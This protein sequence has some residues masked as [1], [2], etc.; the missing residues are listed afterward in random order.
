MQKLTWYQKLGYNSAKHYWRTTT[1]FGGWG[2]HPN[3]TRAEVARIG[4]IKVWARDERD[5]IE[6][7][8][9]WNPER[10]LVRLLDEN[11]K[12]VVKESKIYMP[13]H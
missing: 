13:Y 7:M 1:I 5:R 2:K 11:L 12:Q 8:R 4:R 10:L 6:C 9:V 3:S